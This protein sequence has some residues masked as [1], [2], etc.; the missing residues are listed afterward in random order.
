MN[1][2]QHV[3]AGRQ[4]ESNRQMTNSVWVVSTAT[5]TLKLG[6][7]LVYTDTS[8]NSPFHDLFCWCLFYVQKSE[9]Q[10]MCHLILLLPQI[11]IIDYLPEKHLFFTIKQGIVR[12]NKNT[13][14]I[15][16]IIIIIIKIV[17]NQLASYLRRTTLNAW[18]VR[19]TNICML[20]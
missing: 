8:V 17:I 9:Y 6:N 2:K 15:N 5:L 16:C 12:E 19:K 13:T 7:V 20:L 1:Q 18:S 3:L 10:Q 11:Y 4:K 14:N